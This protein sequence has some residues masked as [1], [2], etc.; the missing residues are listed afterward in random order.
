MSPALRGGPGSR[1]INDI[2]LLHHALVWGYW[3]PDYIWGLT[4]ESRAQRGMLRRIYY[5]HLE[6]GFIV[7]KRRPACVEQDRE[8]LCYQPRHQI[9]R[10][11]AA[12]SL[13]HQMSTGTS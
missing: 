4:T 10:D 11:L 12:V 7:W 13:G 6:E 8:T 2:S 1:L 3:K 9:I 5:N